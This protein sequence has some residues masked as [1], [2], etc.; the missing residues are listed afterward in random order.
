M[1]I[2]LDL[3]SSLLPF[4]HHEVTACDVRTSHGVGGGVCGSHTHV[5]KVWNNSIF[6]TQTLNRCI[7][8]CTQ[9]TITHL[10]T[11]TALVTKR[12]AG[13]KVDHTHILYLIWFCNSRAPLSPPPFFPSSL[14]PSDIKHILPHLT[15]PLLPIQILLWRADTR[16][17][18]H[19]SLYTQPC[20]HTSP[21]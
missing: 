4:S 6:V 3:R 2:C 20:H 19:F 1:L 10:F 17:V 14:P 16:E 18:S 12:A 13:H 15:F 21:Y 7:N 9:S 5:M 11:F 8:K